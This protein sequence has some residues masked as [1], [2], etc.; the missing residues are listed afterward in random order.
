MKAN[1]LF[2]FLLFVLISCKTETPS[3]SQKILFEKHY[4]NYA[5]SYQNNGYLIDSL[6]NVKA[7]NISKDSIKWNEPDKDGYISAAKMNEN[8]A[9]CKTVVGIVPPDSLNFYKDKIIGASY[10]KISE[11]VNQM[12]DAGSIVYS[13]FI[14]DKK[15]NRYQKFLIPY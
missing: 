11:P 15:S 12:A 3:I 8:L 1:Y 5:W 4:T 6:G 14:Y 9:L 2:P 13:A 10:G 7:F